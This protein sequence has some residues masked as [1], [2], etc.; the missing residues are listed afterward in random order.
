MPTHAIAA[1]AGLTGRLHWLG[2]IHS[3]WIGLGVASG[4]ALILQ[5]GPRVS[6]RARHAILVVALLVVA[7]GPVAVAAAQ[8]LIGSRS[9]QQPATLQSMILVSRSA[10]SDSLPTVPS[11]TPTA[12][13]AAHPAPGLAFARG[14][15]ARAAE[16]IRMARPAATRVWWA[17]VA[18]MGSILVLGALGLRRLCR[19]AESAPTSVR[20]RS[21]RLARILRLRTV[22]RI[23]I[24]AGQAEPFLCGLIR[25]I[26]VLPRDWIA[27]AS[28]ACLDAI[29]AHELAHAR[30]RDHLVNLGQRLIEVL[31]FFHPAVHWLS[32]SL[33][34]ERELCADA[35]AV[36][37]TGDPLALAE[38]LQSVARLRPTSPRVPAVGAS[39]GG[40]SLS[41]LS[42]IQELI[43]M[44]PSRPR[45]SLWP[46]AALP[47]AG[48]LALVAAVAG[49]A[50]EPPAAPRSPRPAGAATVH[51]SE[52][53]QRLPQPGVPAILSPA[54]TGS[55][56]GPPRPEPND[57][58]SDAGRFQDDRQVCLEVRYIS[59]DAGPL[60]RIL[61]GLGPPAPGDDGVWIID[62]RGHRDLI[63]GAQQD[64]RT[65]IVSA[66]KVTTFNG[67]RATIISRDKQRYI[68][69][70]EKVDGS[71]QELCPIEKVLEPGCRLDITPTIVPAA[72]RLSIRSE[73]SHLESLV[74]RWHRETIGGQVVAAKYQVP[75]VVERR[76]TL[77]RD[78]P[79]GKHV[80][81][82]L[83]SYDQP[84]RAEGLPG[85]ANRALTSLGLEPI[86]MPPVTSK[87]LVSI[88][89]RKIILEP[90]EE[91]GVPPVAQAK[92][93]SQTR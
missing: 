42:R 59:G 44:T 58:S 18:S 38:A 1:V 89:P 54:R 64:V 31:L 40:P 48:W 22:P 33:R 80:L 61:E 57:I 86:P 49:S 53:G 6:H 39:P 51:S 4:A 81:I 83:G 12:A 30:R 36:R 63:E 41:L 62:D 5:A 29:L 10:L 46:L 32:R 23:L 82:D 7:V 76:C 73:D 3:L 21:R 34:L 85:L 77:D 24:Q 17:A 2:L 9:E 78:L 14:P 69:G 65:N 68:A 84:G 92:V 37:L 25:P 28:P 35:L 11:P 75:T 20:E 91:R 45:L 66:P 93:V 90:E 13:D 52:V 56:H 60:Q 87:L 47:A 8:I 43:G 19:R 55:S 71:P 27:G 50:E 15:L 67:A 74:T 79:D 26:I 72:T 16:G 70:Y 88:T